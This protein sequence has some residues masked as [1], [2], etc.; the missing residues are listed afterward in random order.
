[1]T[2]MILSPTQSVS[3][4]GISVEV[5]LP[6][7]DKLDRPSLYANHGVKRFVRCMRIIVTHYGGP[8]AVRVVEE[9]CP[10]P[11]DGE[12]RVRC[13]PQGSPCPT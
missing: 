11:K 8:D 12:V 9:E 6:T 7:V 3:I 5:F 13:R 2:L 1:M 10:E 4:S